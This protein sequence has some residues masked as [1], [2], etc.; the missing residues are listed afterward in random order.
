MLEVT[1]LS[2]F[3]LPSPEQI[4][5]FAVS[6]STF[7]LLMKA[8]ASLACGTLFSGFNPVSVWAFFSI[9]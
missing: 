6:P 9:V 5:S 4:G 2:P 3:S 8:G 7:M 1:G